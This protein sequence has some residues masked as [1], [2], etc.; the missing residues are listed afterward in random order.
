LFIQ[1]SFITAA[2]L[3]WQI[4]LQFPDESTCTVIGCSPHGFWIFVVVILVLLGIILAS[5]AGWHE[6]SLSEV[7]GAPLSPGDSSNAKKDV[8]YSD[9]DKVQGETDKGQ[10]RLRKWIDE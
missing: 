10:S 5:R 3:A 1:L 7:P 2:V 4:G 8:E 9:L 6:L